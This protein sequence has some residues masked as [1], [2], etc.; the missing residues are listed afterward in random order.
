MRRMDRCQSRC[1]NFNGRVP[2]PNASDRQGARFDDAIQ[3]SRA[4]TALQI[5]HN[6]AAIDRRRPLTSS[7]LILA[8]PKI[9][10]ATI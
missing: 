9:C 7:L 3:R 8:V 10:D 1:A 2:T 5:A 6:P 4:L